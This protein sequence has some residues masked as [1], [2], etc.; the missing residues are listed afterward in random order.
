[1]KIVDVKAIPLRG[2]THDTGWPGGTDPNEQMNTLVEIR[3]DE[4][5]A[6]IG[7]CFNSLPFIE[8]SLTLLKP[9]LIGETAV[10]AERV[11]EKLRQHTFWQGR[12][13][14]VEHAISGLDIAL[15]DLMGKILGQPVSRLLGGNYRSRLK[16]YASILFDQPAV[17]R[18]KLLEQ[19]SRGF[20]AIKMG[21]RPFGRVSRKLDETLIRTA[22]DTVGEDVELMVDAGGSEQFW[23]HGV[24]WARETA[25][26][27]GEHGVV[28]FE[29]ALKPDDLDGFKELRATSPVLIATGEVFTRRQTFQPFITQRALDIIQPDMTKCGGLSE[30]RRMGWMAYDHGVKLVPHGWNTAIGVAADLALTAALPVATWVEYQTGVPYIEQLIEPPFKLDAD[31]LL[32]VPTGPGL[33]VTLNPDAVARFS[34][35]S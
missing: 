25:K 28:W 33:G 27:L 20:K 7:S 29:E 35:K 5:P 31:G 4:G 6:G 1:M 34:R 12:G 14:P 18:E 15:W 13:G 22:R 24:S 32:P 9:L 2:H 26:M 10:E 11:S 21:W 8:A 16:P 3:T 19:T 23:P 17:L 30:G